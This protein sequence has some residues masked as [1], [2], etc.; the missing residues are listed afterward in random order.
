[1]KK[2]WS[3]IKYW[4]IILI[5]LAILF[6]LVASMILFRKYTT[7]KLAITHFTEVLFK[8]GAGQKIYDLHKQSRPGASDD[9]NENH[10]R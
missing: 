2:I 5:F 7:G 10:C 4:V 3:E 8:K 6:E 9:V 1:M